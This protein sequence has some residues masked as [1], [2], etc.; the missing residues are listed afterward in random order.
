VMDAM[1][2]RSKSERRVKYFPDKEVVPDGL[3]YWIAWLTVETSQEGADFA[4]VTASELRIVKP[5]KKAYTSTTEHV[6][7]MANSLNEKIVLEHMDD[8]SRKL[9]C[10]FLKDFDADMWENS[11]DELKSICS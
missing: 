3:L 10:Q 7:D 4:G 6:S 8:K 11:S 5:Y 9:L 1:H 2:A